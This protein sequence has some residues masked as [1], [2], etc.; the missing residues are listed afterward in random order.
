MLTKEQVIEII[1]NSKSSY[2]QILKAHHKETY[3]VINKFYTDGRFSEKVYRWLHSNE[4][5]GRCK[6][7][8]LPTKFLDIDNGY[9]LYCST[10]CSNKGTAPDRSKTLIETNK[11]KHYDYYD[12]I[13]C[14]VCGKEF[15]ALKYREQKCCSGKCCGIYVA[16]SPNRME[17]IK[18][19]KLERYGDEMYVNPDKARETCLKRYGV[20]NIFKS[21]EI[22]DKIKN[23]NL[24][25]Y[26]VEWT[27]QSPVIKEKIKLTNLERYGVENPAQSSEIKL[28]IKDIM[29]EKYGV[30]NIFQHEETMNMIY[31][32]NII[33]YGTKI[34]VNCEELQQQVIRKSYD[35]AY[36]RNVD[37]LSD[38]HEFLFSVEEYHGLEGMYKFKCK[39]CNTKFEDHMDGNGHPRCLIC[40][41]FIAGFSLDEVELCDYVK[42]L[43]GDSNVV[44]NDRSILGG[45]ELD[46]YVPSKMVAI[47]Y[48][49]LYWHSEHSGQK[50]KRYHKNK[51][52]LCESKGIRLIHIFEDEWQQKKNIVKSKIKHILQDNLKEVAIYARKCIIKPID[53]CKEL[54]MNNH[55]QGNC[56]AAIKLGAFYND[57][58][59]AAMT[60][61]NRRVAMGKKTSAVGE[62]ELLRF[63][64]TKRVVGIA[65]KLMSYFI[66]TYNPNK[67]TTYADRRWSVGKLYEN[68]G[69]TL[70]SKTE[71]NY[72]YFKVGETRRWHR[73]NF[74]KDQLPKRL[75]K[76]DIN[77]TEWENCK[78]DGYDRIWD[79]G[80]IKYEWNKA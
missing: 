32:N 7:C 31:A 58:L 71:P 43:V 35:K 36:H 77:L 65:S 25:T 48:N 14:A 50:P 30:D 17:K 33:N 56:P 40:N 37:R 70:V 57:E 60:L 62:Y 80:N 75:S 5:V 2:P 63:A 69:F 55:I 47:E 28:K 49:G 68:I 61:G 76:F 10:K 16:N 72:Y 52:E 46:I 27:F 45:L 39:K 74:R 3:E 11:E 38:T 24:K 13:K 73:F 41:P 54:M 21:P 15:E 6:E 66:K 67:I 42:L 59:V 9:R 26:G 78:A 1:K 12:K 8:N 19:T 22:K 53:D 34:P 20:D 64:T 51:T 23:M 29:N 44:E 18:A 79:S 4:I